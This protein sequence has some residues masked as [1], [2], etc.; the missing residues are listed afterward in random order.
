MNAL[1]DLLAECVALD[2]RLGVGEGHGL[3]VDA[4]RQALTPELIARLTVNKAELLTA[5]GEKSLQRANDS[6]P[7]EEAAA[8]STRAWS[9]QIKTVRLCG[10]GFPSITTAEPPAEI[11]ADPIVLCRCGRG[12][13]LAELRRMTGGRCYECW[14][15]TL[16]SKRR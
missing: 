2:I 4:P 5:I 8:P 16:E 7:C 10:G 11:L 1:D 6:D 13:V 15:K 12:R 3:L 9:R 14:T